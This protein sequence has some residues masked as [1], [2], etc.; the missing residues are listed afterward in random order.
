MGRQEIVLQLNA[1]QRADLKKHL[2]AIDALCDEFVTDTAIITLTKT[3]SR[4]ITATTVVGGVR[5]VT[6]L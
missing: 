2:R 3:E 5:V 4:D 6:P 1:R